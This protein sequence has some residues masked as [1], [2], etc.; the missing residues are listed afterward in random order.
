VIGVSPPE[1]PTTFHMSVRD[2][3]AIALHVDQ[4]G[5]LSLYLH[6][7]VHG[8]IWLSAVL[9]RTP[10][11]RHGVQQIAV[12]QCLGWRTPH[13]GA[14]GVLDKLPAGSRVN[15]QELCLWISGPK[16][17][18]QSVR[19]NC[20]VGLVFQGQRIRRRAVAWLTTRLPR[21]PVAPRTAME[22]IICGRTTRPRH[23]GPPTFECKL[24]IVDPAVPA[25]GSFGAA[26]FHG[27]GHA[28]LT[29]SRPF[30]AAEAI[31]RF[32]SSSVIGGG[33]A[34]RSFVG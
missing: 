6:A 10:G 16:L 23:A 19:H 22:I 34:E 12:R 32:T 17:P 25:A 5:G 30:L 26:C 13:L 28:G 27:H 8:Y 15:P 2:A 14:I 24:W 1:P 31:I 4:N 33:D 29:N 3:P 18:G 7:E 11:E 9:I 21:D 20:A